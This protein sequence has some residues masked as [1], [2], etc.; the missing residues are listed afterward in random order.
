MAEELK[1]WR[2]IIY[3]MFPDVPTKNKFPEPLI[4]KRCG[5]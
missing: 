5:E 1:L 2:S 4:D 3:I